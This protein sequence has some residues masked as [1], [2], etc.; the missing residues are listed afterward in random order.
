MPGGARSG[1]DGVP[2]FHSDATAHRR[3]MAQAITRLNQGKLNGT[4]EVTLRPGETATPVEDPRIAAGSVLLW[5]PRTASAGAAERAGMWV[6][7]RAKGRAI[8]N[9]AAAAAA[10]QDF[11][12][13]I[14][15]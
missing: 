5:M 13:L 1:Y 12:L 10:D 8:L 6:T 9:H 7:G 15:G 14:L 4:L 11:T 3:V 2:E